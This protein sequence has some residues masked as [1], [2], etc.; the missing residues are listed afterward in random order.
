MQPEVHLLYILILYDL[1][2]Y[3]IAASW[4][5]AHNLTAFLSTKHRLE[6]PEKATAKEKPK[7]GNNCWI[8]T[9][10]CIQILNPE[11]FQAYS[12]KKLKNNATTAASATTSFGQ[13]LTRTAWFTL[14]TN[15]NDFNHKF[16]IV[17]SFFFLPMIQENKKKIKKR[18]SL[19][20]YCSF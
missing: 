1:F 5:E 8:Y 18:P 16:Q 15:Q 4:R 2:E 14:I 10:I 13:S 7:S 17:H 9:L 19:S 3:K 6:R 20:T 12:E 11:L